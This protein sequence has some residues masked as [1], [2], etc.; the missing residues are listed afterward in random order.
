MYGLRVRH[1]YTELFYIT[2]DMISNALSDVNL[3]PL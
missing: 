1:F 3:T 2:T